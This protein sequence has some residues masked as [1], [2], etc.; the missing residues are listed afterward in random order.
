MAWN[1]LPANTIQVFAGGKSDLD[2]YAKTLFT[3]NCP[4]V[5]SLEYDRLKNPIQFDRGLNHLSPNGGRETFEFGGN[6]HMFVNQ[7]IIDH[8]N[9]VGVGAKVEIMVLPALAL[10]HGVAVSIYQV[11]VG[12]LFK[13]SWRQGHTMP[14]NGRK[15]A[16]PITN[17]TPDIADQGSQTPSWFNAIGGIATTSASEHYIY[18][19]AGAPVSGNS[20][21]LTLEVV[22]MPTSGVF[23]H[24]N[25]IQIDIMYDVFARIY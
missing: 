2:P 1:P 10:L 15:F 21:A 25:Y 9:K 4:D 11:D 24:A 12:A 8:F 19:D 23:T 3:G 7:Q 5:G 22:Q 17:G 20:D 16:V 13:L 14:G 18:T 6:Q